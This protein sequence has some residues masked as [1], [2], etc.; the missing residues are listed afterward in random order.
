MLLSG[1]LRWACA[2][3]SMKV[4]KNDGTDRHRDGRQTVIHYVFL[5][6]VIREHTASV[7]ITCSQRGSLCLGRGFMS[8]MRNSY[9]AGAMG[10]QRLKYRRLHRRR[11]RLRRRWRE[12]QLHRTTF[13]HRRWRQRESTV[14][15]P[16]L[17]V[18]RPRPR[19][20]SLRHC[21]PQYD[22]VNNT[23]PIHAN[24]THART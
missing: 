22:P 23:T 7:I 21:Q 6:S 5:L 19:R 13:R 10:G 20:S 17:N 11:R 1:E 15:S 12:L 18:W 3:R 2:A 16:T 9:V 4:T 14:T 8:N 24:R